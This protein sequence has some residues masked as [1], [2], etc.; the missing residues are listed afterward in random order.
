MS[1]DNEIKERGVVWPMLVYSLV[2]PAIFLGLSFAFIWLS[3]WLLDGPL[4]FVSWL[5][6]GL[7]LWLV[8]LYHTAGWPWLLAVLMLLPI[9]TVFSASLVPWGRAASRRLGKRRSWLAAIGSF[10]FFPTVSMLA[11]MYVCYPWGFYAF[12]PAISALMLLGLAYIWMC[13][14]WWF[15]WPFFLGFGN[16]RRG[17]GVFRSSLQLYLY[18]S[19]RAK[20]Y[21]EVLAAALG[22]SNEDS[23]GKKHL[24]ITGDATSPV[25]P[26]KTGL[27]E[28]LLLVRI[29]LVYLFCRALKSDWQWLRNLSRFLSRLFGPQPRQSLA[30]QDKVLLDELEY[31]VQRSWY[32]ASVALY[33]E[34][35]LPALDDDTKG[36]A[37]QTFRR[38]LAYT[39]A[40]AECRVL[41]IFHADGDRLDKQTLAENRRHAE[42]AADMFA[43]AARRCQMPTLRATTAQVPR[44][45]FFWVNGNADPG[46]ANPRKELAREFVEREI[47]C[48]EFL[49]GG[50]PQPLGERNQAVFQRLFQQSQVNANLRERMLRARLALA[51]VHHAALRGEFNANQGLV[52]LVGHNLIQLEG[53]ISQVAGKVLRDDMDHLEQRRFELG[54]RLRFLDVCLLCKPRQLTLLEQHLTKMKALWTA[55][56]NGNNPE[57][58]AWRRRDLVVWG[59]ARL[60]QGIAAGPVG[61]SAILEAIDTFKQAEER[62]LP[63]LP[64]F[65]GQIGNPTLL[66]KFAEIRQQVPALSPPAE[67]EYRCRDLYPQVR[68]QRPFGKRPNFFLRWPAPFAAGLIC[69]IACLAF[70]RFQADAMVVTPDPRTPGQRLDATVTGIG[71]GCGEEPPVWV[72]TPEGVEVKGGGRNHFRRRLTTDNSGLLANDVRRVDVSEEQV[73]FL[74]NLEERNGIC[75]SDAPLHAV[76]TYPIFG[77]RRWDTLLGFSSFAQV[78]DQDLSVVIQPPGCPVVLMAAKDA[79]LGIYDFLGRCWYP[80]LDE[81]GGFLPSRHGSITD[82]TALQI[83]DTWTACV[84]AE[85]GLAVGAVATVNMDGTSDPAAKDNWQVVPGSELPTPRVAQVGL[86]KLSTNVPEAVF[87]TPDGGLGSL[88]PGRGKPVVRVGREQ[89]PGLDENGIRHISYNSLGK[90]IWLAD[91]PDDSDHA[92][93]IAVYF[94][95]N[96]QWGSHDKLPKVLDLE[97][98]EHQPRVAFAGTTDGALELTNQA[99]GS[100]SVDKIGPAGEEVLRVVLGDTEPRVGVFSRL[101]NRS[102]AI[103]HRDSNDASADSWH[104][105]VGPKRFPGLSM[106]KVLAAE[107]RVDGSGLLLATDGLGVASVDSDTRQVYPLLPFAAAPTGREDQVRH[108]RDLAIIPGDDSTPGAVEQWLVQVSGDEVMDAID[109]RDPKRWQSLLNNTTGSVSPDEIV[110]MKS[111][112]DTLFLGSP[113]SLTS[114]E[115]DIHKWS[116]RPSVPGLRRLFV[117]GDRMWAHGG[118][119]KWGSLLCWST[120]AKTGW[121][122]AKWT[123]YFPAV[124]AYDATEQ[125]MVVVTRGNQMCLVDQRRR[126]QPIVLPTYLPGGKSVPK[127][128]SIHATFL[129]LTPVEGGIGRYDPAGHRWAVIK[130]PNGM[131]APLR[132]LHANEAGLWVVDAADRLF[133]KPESKPWKMGPLAEQVANVFWCERQALVIRGDGSVSA[134]GPDHEQVLVGGAF[135]VPLK[136]ALREIVEFDGHLFAAVG[137][138]LGRYSLRTHSWTVITP[139]GNTLIDRLATTAGYLYLLDKQGRLYR[140]AAG[141]T[142]SW[143]MLNELLSPVRYLKGFGLS[144]EL[145]SPRVVSIAEMQDA[146]GVIAGSVGAFVIHDRAADKPVWLQA[147]SLGLPKDALVTCATEVDDELYLGTQSHGIW[148]YMSWRWKGQSIPS[149]WLR[150]PHVP[151]GPRDERVEQIVAVPGDPLR[152]AAKTTGG[153]VLFTRSAGGLWKVSRSL[154]GNETEQVTASSKGV[155]VSRRDANG[156]TSLGRHGFDGNTIGLIGAP[157]PWPKEPTQSVAIDPS[158]GDLLR[159][160]LSGRVARYRLPEHAWRPETLGTGSAPI[161]DLFNSAGRLWAW[162]PEKKTL[163]VLT[164]GTWEVFRPSPALPVVQAIWDDDAVLLRLEDGQLQLIDGSRKSRS[165]LPAEAGAFPADWEQAE[166]LAQVKD[167][168]LVGTAGNRVFAYNTRDHSWRAVTSSPVIQLEIDVLDP[169]GRASSY[170]LIDQ[171]GVLARLSLVDGVPH[172][173]AMDLPNGELAKKLVRTT[174][175][176]LL[177]TRSGAL[178]PIRDGVVAKSPAVRPVPLEESAI[179]PLRAAAEWQGNLFLGYGD[180][181][182]G[183]VAVYEPGKMTWEMVRVKEGSVVRFRHTGGPNDNGKLFAEIDLPAAGQDAPSR[184]VLEILPPAGQQRLAYRCVPGNLYD[185]AASEDELWAVGADYR[186]QRYDSGVGKFVD[187]GMAIWDEISASVKSAFV[188]GDEI[189]ALLTNETVWHYA[190]SDLSWR[191]EPDQRSFATLVVTRGQLFAIEKDSGNFFHYDGKD[192]NRQWTAVREAGPNSFGQT[193]NLDVPAPLRGDQWTLSAKIDQ[194]AFAWRQASGMETTPSWPVG[195]AKNRFDFNRF[196]RIEVRDGTLWAETAA[197]RGTE[198]VFRTFAIEDGQLAAESRLGDDRFQIAVDQARLALDEGTSLAFEGTTFGLTVVPSTRDA[199]YWPGVD[200]DGD[201]P[202]QCEIS[203]G[204]LGDDGKEK[205]VVRPA[206]TDQGTVALDVDVWQDFVGAGDS[207]VAITPNGLLRCRLS[208]DQISNISRLKLRPTP[209]EADGLV[210][211]EGTL[212][213]R[214]PAKPSPTYL[215]SDDNGTSWTT[216]AADSASAE[217]ANVETVLYCNRHLE[218]WRVVRNDDGTFQLQLSSDKAKQ[219]FLAIQQ[220][221]GSFI[222]VTLSQGGFGFDRPAGLELTKGE[223]RA[224]T[225]DGLVSCPRDPTSSQAAKLD[226]AMS[227]TLDRPARLIHHPDGGEPVL[228]VD[229]GGAPLALIRRDDRWAPLTDELRRRLLAALRKTLLDTPSWRWNSDETVSVR[230]RPSAKEMISARFDPQSGQF[231][232]DAVRAIHATQAGLWVATDATV[233]TWNSGSFTES[234]LNQVEPFGSQVQARFIQSIDGDWYLKTA[235]ANG[236][237][238]TIFRGSGGRWD[239]PSNPSEAALA[240]AEAERWTLHARTWRALRSECNLTAGRLERR[241][242]L[243][244]GLKSEDYQPVGLLSDR[245]WDFENVRTLGGSED[246]PVLGSL[247]GLRHLLSKTDFGPGNWEFVPTGTPV[248]RIER[249]ADRLHVALR[250]GDERLYESAGLVRGGAPTRDFQTKDRTLLESGRWLWTRDKNSLE[251]KLRFTP[252]AK[253]A[254]VDFRAGRFDV[255][256]VDSIG[257][258]PDEIL[259][260][261]DHGMLNRTFDSQGDFTVVADLPAVKPEDKPRIFATWFDDADRLFL[262]HPS[263]RVHDQRSGKWQPRSSTEALRILSER[264]T[265]V[266]RSLRW[267]IRRLSNGLACRLTV[268]KTGDQPVVF[269][270]ALGGFTFDDYTDVL[271]LDAEGET[272]IL[273]ATRGGMCRLDLNGN[274]LALHAKLNPAGTPRK[275]KT[276]WQTADRPLALI[277]SEDGPEY[278]V[279]DKDHWVIVPR[280]LAQSAVNQTLGTVETDPEGWTIT[281]DVDVDRGRKMYKLSWCDEPLTIMDFARTKFAHD[282]PQSA[283][284]FDN[285]LWVSSIGGV[286]RFDFNSATGQL[287]GAGNRHLWVTPFL[288]TGANANRLPQGRLF[289]IHAHKVDGRKKLVCRVLRGNS[290][291]R[292]SFSEEDADWQ[293]ETAQFDATVLHHV[294]NQWTW[295]LPAPETVRVRLHPETYRLPNPPNAYPIFRNGTCPFWDLESARSTSGDPLA[296]KDDWFIATAGGILRLEKGTLRTKTVYGRTSNGRPLTDVTHLQVDE[297]SGTFLAKGSGMVYR[298][299]PGRDGWITAGEFPAADRPVKSGWLAWDVLSSRPPSVKF[300]PGVSDDPTAGRNSL[301]QDGLFRFDKVRHFICRNAYWLVTPMGIL[302]LDPN[303]G[304]IRHWGAAF[305]GKLD[306]LKTLK[307]LGSELYAIGERNAV[308]KYEG[309]TWTV[310]RPTDSL[311]NQLNEVAGNEIFTC[312][313][314]AGG[315]Y[316]FR[317]EPDSKRVFGPG[318]GTP[319]LIKGGVFGFDAPSDFQVRDD[320]ILVSTRLGIWEYKTAK[321]LTPHARVPSKVYEFAADTRAE[322]SADVPMVDLGRFIPPLTSEQ[323]LMVA[324]ADGSYFAR[325]EEGGWSTSPAGNVAKAISRTLGS[326]WALHNVNGKLAVEKQEGSRKTR[327][328]WDDQNK[329]ELVWSQDLAQAWESKT[330]IWVPLSKRILWIRKSEF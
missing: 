284:W 16:Y 1:R 89:V 136:T 271:L 112:R 116:N 290:E 159:V 221:A 320:S 30:V 188:V 162:A 147:N 161:R 21:F 230:L 40:S 91:A 291:L 212:Y 237:G 228:L 52:E 56:P 35:Q 39:D 169:D 82:I 262:E 122:G 301:F 12:S 206:M 222:P 15:V 255:D 211:S 141:N 270:P 209:I 137:S 31:L 48:L 300:L 322:G 129:Y 324:A 285:S 74:C 172:V 103:R 196:V 165:I 288:S 37:Q 224:Y 287:R 177:F 102:A 98:D 97:A 256:H 187:A 259:L 96:H 283:A 242:K 254:D 126:A 64:E 215:T 101:D 192:A 257:W 244:S 245:S 139:S 184:A 231:S 327:R 321:R 218:S 26:R 323:K 146:L 207:L 319:P 2:G 315:G 115:S 100:L 19:P 44:I 38:W 34:D 4:L 78:D 220:P 223:I 158:N 318:R 25:D 63:A 45:G 93:R 55:N 269:D 149:I 190:L 110:A 72:W 160:E 171:Q 59:M 299:D 143:E 181:R 328:I 226:Q 186:I 330:S 316:E 66:N 304:T 69:L 41:D 292:F 90:R 27:L 8:Y 176:P 281:R 214:I 7:L 133:L 9:L 198:P 241:F 309:T 239:V 111:Y 5:Y 75:F 200:T 282:V 157:Y 303:D 189:V 279:H 94:E 191:R 174:S 13:A 20:E 134:V 205:V 47:R 263:G 164:G 18:R 293:P 11:L 109:L 61:T 273:A 260:A 54:C 258:T 46:G 144:R 153:A 289:S 295:H 213:A 99:D 302:R 326:G 125:Q 14:C 240:V 70:W 267:T 135:D 95:Q 71:P 280:D 265:L 60:A 80:T 195:F 306:E 42:A 261:S 229:D 107:P 77:L 53:T 142:G 250:D 275:D 57:A 238:Q 145:S 202:V 150:L 182:S 233:L 49:C 24:R 312:R 92:T 108:A 148:A 58:Q 313:Q 124:N 29:G 252:S 193:V 22:D 317:L 236:A 247:A 168:L 121:N 106:E 286:L 138:K 194:P 264:E 105:T 114:Y 307:S 83:G 140:L 33:G 6:N 85:N 68:G 132:R 155:F 154:G 243:A 310:C 183:S 266:A 294:A 152:L 329:P 173:E 268:G 203:L 119:G 314:V 246:D 28:K 3:L 235:T 185:V 217:M 167:W 84:G 166:Y 175:G 170:C 227:T 296:F 308:W 311:L 50:S 118:D 131:T 87:R 325:N 151:G 297:E 51:H 10:V 65:V 67:P 249:E 234:D 36:A 62:S 86:R 120:T 178:Y 274:L 88:V 163:Y 201:K 208:N 210:F 298:Y 232:F 278:Y 277:E 23:P 180:K 253:L 113:S 197:S 73:V 43:E 272:E 216:P 156:A 17:F 130:F 123:E 76:G 128:A 251:I 117:S 199:E 81:A 248:A 79:G 179:P 204:G 305:S 219:G 104:T 32:E 225:L 276:L 127:L